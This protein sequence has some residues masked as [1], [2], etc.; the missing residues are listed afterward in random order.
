MSDDGTEDEDD[1]L[2][3]W[4]QESVTGV[5]G[6]VLVVAAEVEREL[7]N[8]ITCYLGADEERWDFVRHD[9]LGS[10]TLGSKADLLRRVLS[11]AGLASEFGALNARLDELVRIRNACA[12]WRVQPNMEFDRFDPM[13]HRLSFTTL[14]KRGG[15]GKDEVRLNL[16]RFEWLVSV[17]YDDLYAVQNR[18]DRLWEPL[19][20][21]YSPVWVPDSAHDPTDQGPPLR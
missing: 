19:L 12:H 15:K 6:R 16:R 8:A 21:D 1:P 9:L 4:Q 5:I 10:M 7:D 11:H 13:A 20:A 14:S 3:I 2:L 17:L 18:L